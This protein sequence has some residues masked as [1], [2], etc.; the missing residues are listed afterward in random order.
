ME[1][2]VFFGNG[3]NLLGKEEKSWDNVLR[4][5]SQRQVLPP[6]GNN[7]LKYEYVVLPKDRYTKVNH[8][9]R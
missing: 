6:I 2:T 7:T 9:Y 3:V 5:L 1:S 4:Q 8:G